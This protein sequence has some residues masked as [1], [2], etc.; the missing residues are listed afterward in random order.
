MDCTNYKMMIH[1]FHDGILSKET[2]P[3][4]FTHLSQCSECCDILK[5]LN[6]ISGIHQSELKILDNCIDISVFRTIAKNRKDVSHG[7]FTRKVP[8]FYAYTLLVILFLVVY[9]F[10]NSAA[11]YKTGLENAVNEIKELNYNTKLLLEAPPE[12]VVKAKY[13]KNEIVITPKI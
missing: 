12:Y 11:N 7:M 2:E 13:T 1:E 3:M 4:L 6:T 8:A 10:N 5:A 9:L